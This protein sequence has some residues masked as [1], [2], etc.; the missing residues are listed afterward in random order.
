MNYCLFLQRCTY[1][2]SNS[3]ISNSAV[4]K[5]V[6][7]QEGS[8]LV[9]LWWEIL[10]MFGNDK[11]LLVEV[12]HA[13]MNYQYLGLSYL[14]K[15]KSNAGNIDTAFDNPCYYAKKN[16]I[17]FFSLKAFSHF[18]FL[19]EFAKVWEHYTDKGLGN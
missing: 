19:S 9:T 4:I 16:S 1:M 14:P 8:L 6:L 5:D 2:V 11:Q 13:V 10:H 12:E 3:T 17:T 18:E 7:I 15:P